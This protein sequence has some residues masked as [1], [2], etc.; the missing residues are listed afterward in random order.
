MGIHE[1]GTLAAATGQLALGVLTALR[2]GHNPLARPLSLLCFVTFGWNICDLAFVVSGDRAWNLLDHVL[3]PMTAPLFLDFALVLT[4]R[5]RRYG[6]LLRI[7]YL[8]LGLLSVSAVLSFVW[9]PALDFQLSESW[10][11]AHLAVAMPAIGL[12]VAC[13]VSQRHEADVEG[14]HRARLVLGGIA[15]AVPLA[16]TDLLRNVIPVEVPRL[17]NLATLITAGVL[18]LVTLRLRLFGRD[19][20]TSAISFAVVLS[21]LVALAFAAL[22]SLLLQSVEALVLVACTVALIVGLLVRAGAATWA[23]RHA[24]EAQLLNLGRFAAQM[25]HDLKNPLAA[26]KGRRPVPPR[27]AAPRWLARRA[28]RVPGPHPGPGRAHGAV[29]RRLPAARPR[30]SR[31]PAARR[32]RCRP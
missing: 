27:G 24:R 10:S 6:A 16:V 32:E 18:T 25:G 20:S 22:S 13:L 29:A 23:E 28:R 3:S 17:A 5:R 1:W 12:A 8:L 30:R 14:W 26:L 2:G 19:L 9:R 31:P 15:I 21:L 4:G 11:V 7:V